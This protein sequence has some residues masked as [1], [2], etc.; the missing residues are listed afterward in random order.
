L[1]KVL[2]PSQ[3]IFNEITSTSGQSSPSPGISRINSPTSFSPNQ[4]DIQ[5]IRRK[6]IKPVNNSFLA[7]R[8]SQSI[9]IDDFTVGSNTIIKFLTSDESLPYSA[10]NTSIDSDVPAGLIGGER[11]LNMMVT[12]NTGTFVLIQTSVGN[13]QWIFGSPDRCNISFTVV[14]DGI[15]DAFG[16]SSLGGIDFT[17]F[18]ATALG[19]TIATDASIEVTILITSLNETQCY[20]SAFTSNDL[21]EREIEF[22]Y[23]NFNGNC[24][25]TSVASVIVRLLA[26]NVEMDGYVTLIRVIGAQVSESPTTSISFSPSMSKSSSVSVTPS[27]SQSN[28]KSFSRTLSESRSLSKSES[29][30]RTSTKSRTASATQSKSW[31]MTQSPTKS[32]SPTQTSSIS[33]TREKTKSSTTSTTPISS[34]SVT[35]T[36]STRG[37][38]SVRPSASRAVSPSSSPSETPARSIS[39]TISP[40]VSVIVVVLDPGNSQDLPMGS[41]T[42]IDEPSVDNP[43]YTIQVIPTDDETLLSNILEI[44]LLSGSFDG[45][46]QLCF[47]AN[48]DYETSQ[49]CLGFLDESVNPPIWKCEDKCLS[50]TN[51]L[52]CGTTTH[53]TNFAILLTGN[54]YQD[55]DS[56]WDYIISQDADLVLLGCLVVLVWILLLMF[57][58]FIWATPLGQQ[59]FYGKEGYRILKLRRIAKS[60]RPTLTSMSTEPAPDSFLRGV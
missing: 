58:C 45:T 1:K 34:N 12:E 32:A 48:Q 57:V 2:Y 42:I 33:I 39:A 50:S 11:Q 5:T 46:A 25:L 41:I 55:C 6:S 15:D 31:S 43:V 20:Q 35:K 59:I 28:S 49:I 3:E 60:L 36:I 19:V 22:P 10:T 56:T 38:F 23:A 18:S 24:D 27:V 30:S 7:S 54:T 53:F 29:P 52:W 16:S 40:S 37:V 26:E 21:F 8:A 47:D 14:Y 51:D 9:I 17:Q 44:N 13:G 4:Q